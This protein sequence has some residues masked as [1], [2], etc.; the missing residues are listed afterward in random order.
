MKGNILVVD[1]NPS[2]LKLLVDTLTTEGYEVRPTNNGEL[3]LISLKVKIPDLILLD[4]RMPDMDG[5]EVCRRIKSQ[6][7]FNNIPIMF[8]SA[9]KETEERVKGLEIGAVD[10]ISKPFQR[11]ELLVRV[12]THLELSNFRK[13]LEELVKERT[14][15][16]EIEIL[17]HKKAQELLAQSEI[18]FRNVFEHSVDAI[19]VLVKGIHKFVNP[20]YVTLFGYSSSEELVGTPIIDLIT[21]EEREKIYNNPKL[22]NDGDL[23]A[24]NYETIGYKK[25]GSLFNID[26]HISNYELN[27]ELN[28]LVIL[29][30]ITIWKQTEIEIKKLNEDLERRV[31]DRTKELETSNKELEAFSYSVSHDLRAPL[32]HINGYANLLSKSSSDVL[33]EQGKTY[34]NNIS[35]SV[36]LMGGLIDDLLKFSRTSRQELTYSKINMNELHQCIYGQI[37]EDITNRKIKWVINN[38]PI[39]SADLNLIKAV[40]FNLISNAIKFTQKKEVSTIEIGSKEDNN[41]YIFFIRDNGVGFDMQ[42]KDKLFGVFQRL[43]SNNEF[44]GTGIGLANVRRI[45]HRHGG[46][47]WAEAEVD[48][49]ATFYFTLPKNSNN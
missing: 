37:K 21:P 49:G 3:A 48:K 5:F 36:A 27:N 35:K 10:F 26:V 39:I 1:D 7:D 43:H 38:L 24:N 17:H 18:K 33:S 19:G 41:E 4:V 8:I 2:N 23:L 16:L 14:E 9:A 32:R 15:K 40:W 13:N 42:Y 22:C 46:R 6:K 47:V 20:S 29:R 30:D 45:I 34:L 11:E 31:I 44:E 12:K 28:S 25:D